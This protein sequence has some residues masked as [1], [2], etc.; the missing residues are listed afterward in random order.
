MEPRIK[1][2]LDKEYQDNPLYP[3]YLI[4]FEQFVWDNSQK[5]FIRKSNA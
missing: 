1:A 3:Y 2:V 5:A 4:Y